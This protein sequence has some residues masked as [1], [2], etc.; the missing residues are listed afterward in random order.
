MS[1]VADAKTV[2][3]NGLSWKDCGAAAGVAAAGRESIVK[4]DDKPL[5]NVPLG[6]ALS[7]DMQTWHK[8]EE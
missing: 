6:M 2:H 4:M 3:S 7:W 1:L 5:A 8:Q